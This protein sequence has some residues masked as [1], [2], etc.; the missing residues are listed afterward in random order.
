MAGKMDEKILCFSAALLDEL[1]RF[2]GI[3]FEVEKYFPR[4]VTPP[5]CHYVQRG[6]AENDP[7]EKQVIPYAL[8][9]YRDSIFAYRRGKRGSESRLRELYSVGV[10]GHIDWMK[11]VSLFKKDHEKYADAMLREI[12]EE[13]NLAPGYTESCVALIND[14]SNEVGKVH[15]GVVHLFKLT[16][17]N[18]SKKESVITDAGLVPVE[19]AVRDCDKYE[20]WSQL[21]LR[22]IERLLERS[23]SVAS[24]I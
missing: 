3:S 18:I 14:D 13:V 6:E 19:R 24:M 1:G 7:S 22:H 16:D 12:A 15:F 23:A 8:F 21:C 17:S 11:D 10:G 4:I 5:D 2:Q 20:T 9:L